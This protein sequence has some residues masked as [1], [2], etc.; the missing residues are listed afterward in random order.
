MK[1]YSLN[2]WEPRDRAFT[3]G[4]SFAI[5]L[6]MRPE[7][8]EGIQEVMFD[9]PVMLNPRPTALYRPVL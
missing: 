3:A 8:V 5:P 4:P 7:E 9:V 6:N 1:V 2:S